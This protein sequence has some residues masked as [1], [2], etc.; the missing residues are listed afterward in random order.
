MST[1]TTLTLADARTQ[2]SGGRGYLA[3]C[4]LGLPTRDTVA[5]LTADVSDWAA[6]RATTA[7]Y[8]AIVEDVR[9]LY[10]AIVDV[11]VSR[12]AIGSQ[13]SVMAALIAESVPDGAEVVCIDGD[14]SSMVFPFLAQADRGVSVRHVPVSELAEGIGPKTWLVAFSLVQSATGEIA[15]AAAIIAAARQHG[16]W[17]LCD[18]TQA[19]GWLPVDA[20]Q[21]DAT[22]CH[23]YKWL[24]APR[25]A[26]FLTIS[27]RFQSTLRPAQA[28]WYAGAD[29]WESCYGPDMVLAP[30]A[31]RFDVSPAWPAWVG[32]KPALQLFASLDIA[33]LRDTVVALGDSLCDGLGIERKGQPIV[34]WPDADGT[35]FSRLSDAGLTVSRR[36]GR[37]RVAFHVWNDEQDV[38]D[39]LRA[40]RR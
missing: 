14:F 10:A 23:S 5:A 1:V 24:C 16:A 35:S 40:L 29:P 6:G 3:A 21:F 15:D 26:A 37:A 12:V 7:N 13:V 17:T 36:A 27:E 4:T 18:T 31:R 11:P 34:S 39:A 20:G 25:G 9:S 19:T 22:V 2:F 38:D 28:G 32:A 30:D 8:G 33:D